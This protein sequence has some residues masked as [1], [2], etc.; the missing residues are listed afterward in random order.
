MTTLQRQLDETK[1]ERD[2]YIAFEKEVKKEKE[3]D[4]Q[5]ISKEVAEKRIEKLK[6]EE[7]KAIA[8]VK[9]AEKEKQ[10]LED[11]IKTLEKEERALEKQEAE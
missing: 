5:G 11:E 1:K 2:G 3:K 7:A 8:E 9:E 6:I 4:G 10:R